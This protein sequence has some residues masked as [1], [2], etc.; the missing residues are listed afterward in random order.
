MMKQQLLE[1]AGALSPPSPEAASRF[2]AVAAAIA[3]EL[4]RRMAQRPDLEQLIGPG[5]QAMMEDNS[6]NFLRFMSTLFSHYDAEVL[7]DSA[8]WAIRTYRAHGFQLS[9]WPAN[10]ATTLKIVREQLPSTV[11]AE[12][13]P[14]FVWLSDNLPALVA[15]HRP[16]P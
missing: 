7:V 8:L 15:L 12:V 14:F 1:S 9:Y 6:R 13:Q 16:E 2:A 3:A 10:I 5:N 11:V 4:T